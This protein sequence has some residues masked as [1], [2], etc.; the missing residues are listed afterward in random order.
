MSG[1]CRNPEQID[2]TVVYLAWSPLRGRR[3]HRVRGCERSETNS[4]ERSE[5][6]D[7]PG[8]V[9]IKVVLDAG[10]QCQAH[11]RSTRNPEK[12]LRGQGTGRAGRGRSRPALSH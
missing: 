11:A 3:G 9:L 8:I 10:W 5:S 4:A 12:E 6:L 2:S 1:L 7:R